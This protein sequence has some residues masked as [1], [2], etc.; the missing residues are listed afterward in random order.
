M[1]RLVGSWALAISI[2]AMAS[3]A[4]AQDED[5]DF[6]ADTG[7]TYQPSQPAPLPPSTTADPRGTYTQSTTGSRFQRRAPT[8]APTQQPVATITQ[9]PTDVRPASTPSPVTRSTTTASTTEPRTSGTASAPASGAGADATL[10]ASDEADGEARS[11]DESAMAPAPA[12]E[13]NLPASA[14]TQQSPSLG[15]TP[16][17]EGSLMWV[18]ILGTIA[19]AFAAG[20]AAA[21][22]LMPWP[23][24]KVR[25]S[26]QIIPRGI[27]AGTLSLQ[28][29]DIE[30]RAH[31]ERGIPLL[32]GGVTID[33]ERWDD[34]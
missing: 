15:D 10:S 17:D 29:P 5:S 27:P 23:R 32:A 33:S 12:G 25:A 24:P 9:N 18:I 13:S 30:V 16:G 19:A 8:P 4:L 22:V 34:E 1:K 14:P 20:L 28:A 11:I 6:P 31:A 2:W 26:H 7:S 3:P 21:K